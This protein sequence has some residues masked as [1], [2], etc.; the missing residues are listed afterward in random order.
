M[1]LFNSDKQKLSFRRVKSR[2]IILESVR[3]PGDIPPRRVGCNER[4]VL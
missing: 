4:G 1:L 3:T 2:K